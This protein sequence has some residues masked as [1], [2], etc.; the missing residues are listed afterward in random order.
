MYNDYE[1][2]DLLVHRLVVVI[3]IWTCP[4]VEGIWIWTCLP[5][6]AVI[7]TLT[8][9]RV[10]ASVTSCLCLATSIFR[11]VSAILTSTSPSSAV[12]AIW[13]FA[14]I[15]HNNQPFTAHKTVR[16]Q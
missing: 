6:V 15:T 9:P 10:G 14:T 3:L 16:N 7:L 4:Y 2:A 12:T 8:C 13:S 11:D 5:Y 1:K